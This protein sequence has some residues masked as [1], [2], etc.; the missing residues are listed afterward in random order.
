MIDHLCAESWG[1]YFIVEPS[2]EL[3]QR[4][5]S[6]LQQHL[7]TDQ[8]NKVQWLSALPT[9]FTGVVLANEVMD[10]LPVERVMRG[11]D[12]LAVEVIEPSDDEENAF[13]V[14]QLPVSQLD[15]AE[16]ER[17]S[18]AV[19]Y[20]ENDLCYPWP[21]GYCSEVSQLLSP[22]VKSLADCLSNGVL[23][24]IDYGYPRREY[25][26]PERTQGTLQCFYRH[27]AH[28]DVTLWPGLQD[29]TAH[30]DFTSVVE[31]GDAAGLE[32]LGY[33]TQAPFLFGC[34]LAEKA[35]SLPAVWGESDTQS[36][37]SRI[38]HQQAVNRLTLPGEMGERFQVM[39]LGRG[40]DV[41]LRGFSI[42]DLSHR[43]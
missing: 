18:D 43:L 6:F 22:W 32:L 5:H 16:R 39:A 1:G 9:V 15:S 29:I 20:I 40:V 26:L 31:A 12:G 41:P 24:L 27:H 23:L 13:V 33:T 19:A 4:Q 42:L 10:A 28:S 25:Y 38:Q 8:F 36:P 2:A 34:G 21:E 3:R 7:A 17:M 11:V 30:V 37:A 35:A 14:A